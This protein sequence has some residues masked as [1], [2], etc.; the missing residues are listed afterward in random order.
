MRR[1]AS[2]TP[3][4]NV[5]RR[6]APCVEVVQQVRDGRRRSTGPPERPPREGGDDAPGAGPLL[7]GRGRPAGEDAPAAGRVAGPGRVEGPLDADA[8]DARDAVHVH[9]VHRR[10]QRLQEQRIAGAGLLEERD[11]DGA[12][13]GLDRHAHLQPLVDGFANARGSRAP[14][15]SPQGRRRC[16]RNTRSPST[17]NSRSCGRHQAAGEAVVG[18]IQLRA[19]DVLAVE[20]EVLRDQQAAARAERQALDVIELMA[21]GPGG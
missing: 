11:A 17:V 6:C 3:P 1:S 16:S 18:A 5:P 19:D 9:R 12:R 20:R 15:P 13:P 4:S 8:V 7:G 21:V 2:C 14:G 10:P